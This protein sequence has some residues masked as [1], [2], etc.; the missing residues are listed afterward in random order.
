MFK[1]KKPQFINIFFQALIFLFAF[2][3]FTARAEVII[4]QSIVNSNCSEVTIGVLKNWSTSGL[5]EELWQPTADYLTSQLPCN[6]FKIKSISFEDVSSTIANREVDFV[7]LN[8]D[9]YIEM[10]HDYGIS[11]VAT[12]VNK[13]QDKVFSD[14]GGVIFT[15]SDRGDINSFADLRG[16][17][18][19]AVNPRSF[20]GWVVAKKE[21][22]DVGINPEKDF[23]PLYFAG[24]HDSAVFDVLS[25]RADAGTARTDTIEK[26]ID[27]GKISLSDLKIINHRDDISDNQDFPLL[28]STRLYPEWP[29]AKLSDVED[30]LSRNIVKSLFDLSP[31]HPANQSAGIA[32]WTTARNYNPVSDILRSLRLPPFEDYGKFSLNQAISAYW[33]FF[34]AILILFLLLFVLLFFTLLFFRK[35]KNDALFFRTLL[36]SIPNPIF[37]KDTRGRYLG[38][39]KAFFESILG[40][41]RNEV[42]G[43]TA[44]QLVSKKLAVLYKAKDDELFNNPGKQIYE[45]EVKFSDG[46]N[47]YCKFYKATYNDIRGRVIGLVGVISDISQSKQRE[48]K[49]LEVNQRFNIQQEATLNILEDLQN[50]KDRAET[51]IVDLEKFRLAVDGASD[52][53]LITDADGIIL[54]ANSSVS[55][56]TGFSLPEILGKKAGSKENWG[57]LMNS[58]FYNNFWKTI[59]VDRRAIRAEV[60]NRRKNGENYV[61]AAT[62]SPIIDDL[63]GEVKF[64]VGI[65]RDITKEK[66][67]DKAKTEFVSLASHQLRTPLSAINWYTEMLLNGDAGKLNSEQKQYLNEIYSGNQRMV[68]LV[69]SLLNVSRLELG[70]FMIEPKETDLVVLAQAVIKELQPTIDLK[71]IKFKFFAVNNLPTLKVDPK[72]MTIVF[73]NLLSNAVKYTPN[74]GSV[75]LSLLKEKTGIK[76]VVTD[77]GYGIPKHQQDKIFEKLFRA[78]N[79]KA[80]D[81]EGTG[82]GLYLVKSIIDQGGGRLDF[83]SE[84]NKGSEFSVFL[85]SSGMKP[86]EGTKKLS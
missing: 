8:P 76:I 48:E 68:D 54:Y 57:G 5:V 74:E 2:F 71:K 26:L 21:L 24:A 33:Q 20:G 32:G 25:G 61:A 49:L 43:K 42:I 85:P 78:D 19:V 69:N 11:R 62:I 58:E 67:V 60:N 9:L 13:Y 29:L 64:F 22:F 35:N 23:S 70:T 18:F 83:K 30:S 44:S 1:S 59:K 66:Q 53:I 10:E 28:H 14:F 72:L 4:N 41:S 73:Q 7:L 12:I 34:L 81:T 39:N 77:T 47:H 45:S 65:E 17:R 36:E 31:D 56:I 50:E 86:K 52:H 51:L 79:V 46:L 80:L 38:G 15:R 27:A 82:L 40:K 6:T 16:K 55:R 37:F 63:T 75:S 84:E 3:A